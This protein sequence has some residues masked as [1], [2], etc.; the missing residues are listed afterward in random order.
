MKILVLTKINDYL[1]SKMEDLGKKYN[2]SWIVVPGKEVN[3]VLPEIDAI[4]A[5]YVAPEQIEIAKNL[6]AIFVPWAG[7]DMLP[8]DVIKKKGV[9][10]ANSHG[11]GKIV[12]ERALALAL[13]LTARVVEYHND[14]LKGIWHGFAVGFKKEDLWFS[15]Q[16]KN[17]AILGTGTIGRHLAKLLRGFGCKIIGFKRVFKEIKDFD[18][19]TTSIESAIK[20]AHVVFVTLP[21]TK[22]TYHIINKKV[23][24]LMKNKFLI[25][26]GRGE[27]IEEKALYKALENKILAGYASD[28]WYNYPGKEKSVVLPFNYPI[29]KF[30]N[31]VISPHVGGYTIEGQEGRIDELI[32]NIEHFIMKGKPKNIVDPEQ[33]Y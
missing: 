19:I 24:L 17:V 18:L 29:H 6:K 2:I 7:A 20:D 3:T 31:V 32:E 25:N 23:L 10:V 27:L 16:N 8:W 30:K 14:L 1:K 28:V 15:L 9:F 21:L 5:G 26:V 4:V 13:T 33:M 11:N 12:A 22:E